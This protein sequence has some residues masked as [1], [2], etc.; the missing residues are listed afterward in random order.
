MRDFTINGEDDENVVLQTL[1]GKYRIAIWDDRV[2]VTGD[3]TSVELKTGQVTITAPVM[4]TLQAP[5]INLNG[6]VNSGGGPGTPDIVLTASN[7]ITLDA[8][9][10]TI[11]GRSFLGHHH[12]GVVPGGG[13]SGNVV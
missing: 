5:N 8:P 4:V 9:T 10:V 7:S 11:Q 3:D 12:S 6:N 1:D 2:K 13:N